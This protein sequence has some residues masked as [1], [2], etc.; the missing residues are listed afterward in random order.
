MSAHVISLSELLSAR[1]LH[2]G[3]RSAPAPAEWRLATLQG[4]LVEI[5]GGGD[6]AA[7]SLSAGL[8]V[9]AQGAEAP[10]AWV[11]AHRDLFY[12]PDL[13]ACG[14]DLSALPVVLAPGVEA[15]LVA[16]DRLLRSGAFGLVVLDLGGASELP[17][18]AQSRLAGLAQRHEAA[19]VCL[20]RKEADQGSLGALVSLRAQARRRALGGG[21]YALGLEVLKDKRRGP[22]WRHEEVRRGPLGLC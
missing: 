4:R 11:G 10:V 2:R 5:S 19:L 9:E 14:V 1:H 12:P 13:A 8:I 6:S 15:A 18:A 3:G 20:T 7:L 22:G 21:R 16:S 17:L